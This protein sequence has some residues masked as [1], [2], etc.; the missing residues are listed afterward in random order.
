M[1]PGGLQNN[2]N[3]WL[4]AES[5]KWLSEDPI[6][7][8]G[9]DANLSRYV[10]NHPAGATDPNGLAYITLDQVFGEFSLS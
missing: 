3:R 1:A 7:F 5:G 6:S 8:N 9:G 2:L 4:D 10:G